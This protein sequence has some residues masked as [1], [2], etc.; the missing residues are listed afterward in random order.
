MTLFILVNQL[1]FSHAPKLFKTLWCF[2]VASYHLLSLFKG[3]TFKHK[4]NDYVHLNC[5]FLKIFIL[6]YPWPWRY[7]KSHLGFQVG[8]RRASGHVLFIDFYR[9]AL[10]LC[11]IGFQGILHLEK[12]IYHIVKAACKLL[13]EII[14]FQ[15]ALPSWTHTQKIEICPIKSF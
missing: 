12:N 14:V 2:Y 10:L 15:R 6:F 3:H 5:C 11:G 13:L 9:V 1:H 8:W 7:L 4:S